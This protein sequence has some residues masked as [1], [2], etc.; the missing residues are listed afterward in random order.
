MFSTKRIETTMKTTNNKN[1]YLP[2]IILGVILLYVGTKKA[3]KMIVNGSNKD[4]VK[5]IYPLAE[6][7]GNKIGVPPLF[8]TAQIC[9]ETR[10]G[11]SSLFI[12]NYNVGGIKAVG[13]QPYVTKDTIEYINDVKTPVKRKFAT[14]PNLTTGL[15]AYSKVF[16]NKYF[17]QYLNKTKDPYKYVELL[18]SGKPKYA[19]DI[20]YVPKIKAVI[21]TVKQL[22]TD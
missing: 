18:Q 11:K 15:A 16:M 4:F 22:L 17:K 14:Y 21:D 8:L 5:F 19:T 9:L 3:T 2:F 7:I 12:E 1:Q 13:T 20:N 10:Y 6:V